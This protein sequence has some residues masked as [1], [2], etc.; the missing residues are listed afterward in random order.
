M[1][2]GDLKKLGYTSSYT[3]KKYPGKIYSRYIIS[4]RANVAN[5]AKVLSIN[6]YPFRMLRKWNN[7]Q[8]LPEGQPSNWIDP[9]E[10]QP[11]KKN[12][13]IEKIL[14]ASSKDS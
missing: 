6:D 4:G 7:I 13:A 8:E 3:I 9:K 5:V 1:V 14:N 10:I 11:K 2:C 12:K